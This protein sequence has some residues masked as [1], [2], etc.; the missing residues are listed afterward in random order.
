M[1][2]SVKPEETIECYD[3][4]CADATAETIKIEKIKSILPHCTRVTNITTDYNPGKFHPETFNLYY[5]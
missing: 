2:G 5:T 4:E 1:F 3:C